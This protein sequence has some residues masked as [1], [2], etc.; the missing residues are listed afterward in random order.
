MN[1]YTINILFKDDNGKGQLNYLSL[2]EP[3]G[4]HTQEIR[5][6]SIIVLYF[7]CLER[8]FIVKH[9]FHH[10]LTMPSLEKSR[11]DLL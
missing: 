7:D 6:Y 11:S 1:Q 3:F 9:K 5:E 8:L 10:R 2:T 4:I